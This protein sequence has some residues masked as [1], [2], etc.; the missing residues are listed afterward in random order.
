MLK[1][2]S[3][4]LLFVSVL[5]LTG[6]NEKPMTDTEIVYQIKDEL[7]FDGSEIIEDVIIPTTENEDV[8]L[9]WTSS[10]PE[11]LAID[12]TIT[13]PEAITGDLNV[14]LSVVITLNDA[15]AIKTFEFTVLAEAVNTELNTDYTD[16]TTMSFAY[17]DSDFLPDGI[18]EVSLVACVDGDTAVFM[19]NGTT[20]NVRFLGINTP[21]STYKFE[22]WGKPAS[23]FTCAKLTNAT[24][25]VL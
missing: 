2:L 18:G 12:G 1:K 11:V 14:S 25:I 8:T 19:E 9:E 7:S 20:F 23:V 6:C 17:E 10:R 15:M 21:E 13:R 22:P 3:L 4:T 5:I 24:T 16:T